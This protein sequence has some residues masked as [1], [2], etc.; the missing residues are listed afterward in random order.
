MFYTVHGCKSLGLQGFYTFRIPEF[1]RLGLGFSLM[2]EIKH[3]EVQDL[4]SRVLGS[5]VWVEVHGEFQ[6]KDCLCLEYQV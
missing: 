3:S 4:G 5:R 2:S 6:V 1:V